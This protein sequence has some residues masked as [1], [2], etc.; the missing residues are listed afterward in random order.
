MKVVMVKIRTIFAKVYKAKWMKGVI[1][2]KTVLGEGG[3]S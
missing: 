2:I 1:N 3:V